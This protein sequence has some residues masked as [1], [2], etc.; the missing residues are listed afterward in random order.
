MYD[1][2]TGSY[3]GHSA[4]RLKFDGARHTRYSIQ[5]PGSKATEG[6]PKCLSTPNPKSLSEIEARYSLSQQVLRMMPLCL[7]LLDNFIERDF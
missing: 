4:R 1:S 7:G 6:M 5:H 2:S 3:E